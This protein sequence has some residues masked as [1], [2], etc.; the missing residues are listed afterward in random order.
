VRSLGSVP[1]DRTLDPIP[2]LPTMIPLR[3]LF[4]R[5]KRI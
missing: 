5:P 2:A 4:F 3:F 1:E